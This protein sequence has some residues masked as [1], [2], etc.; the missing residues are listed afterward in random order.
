MLNG[1]VLIVN[2]Q[3]VATAAAHIAAREATDE[4]RRGR[5]SRTP[6]VKRGG[7]THS[8]WLSWACPKARSMN[9]SE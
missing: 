2:L 5:W 6:L 4:G 3:D 7:G 8:V 1:H 9:S